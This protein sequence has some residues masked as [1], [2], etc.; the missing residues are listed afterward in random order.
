MSNISLDI[1]RGDLFYAD[2]SPVIGS[3]QGGV[4]P[5]LIIQNNIGNKY[6]PTV[7]IA[8]ITSQINKAKLPTHIEIS[9]SEYGLNKD[10]V[11]LLEQIRTI[12]KSR[13]IEGSYIG[14]VDRATMKKIDEAMSISVGLENQRDFEVRKQVKEVEYW[15]RTVDDLLDDV[16]ASQEQIKQRAVRL[17]MEYNK[18][19]EICK[20]SRVYLSD[21]LVLDEL[22]YEAI[23][24]TK[25]INK[26][27]VL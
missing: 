9:S 4:R 27:K 13:I 5:V 3:E 8:A 18:L 20:N 2:L 19:K 15:M 12:D 14:R 23:L 10:S 21:Y 17:K 6:S 24:R 26:L 25:E 16:Y 1:K 7:I 22:K 11:I